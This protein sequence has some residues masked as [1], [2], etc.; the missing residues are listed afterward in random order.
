MVIAYLTRSPWSWTYSPWPFRWAQSSSTVVLVEQSTSWRSVWGAEEACG[1]GAGSWGSTAP[2]YRHTQPRWVSPLSQSRSRDPNLVFL[3]TQLR[4]P[5]RLML[6]CWH[7]KFHFNVQPKNRYIKIDVTATVSLRSFPTH[8]EQ[9]M[10]AVADD[11][12]QVWIR[13]VN[14]CNRS[15]APVCLPVM[16]RSCVIFLRLIQF[17]LNDTK[18]GWFRGQI[19]DCQSRAQPAKVFEQFA[20][21]CDISDRVLKNNTEGLAGK[22]QKRIRAVTHEL[23]LDRQLQCVQHWELRNEQE[24]EPRVSTQ[25]S[26]PMCKCIKI[27]NTMQRAEALSPQLRHGLLIIMV[28]LLTLELHGA[29]LGPKVLPFKCMKFFQAKSKFWFTL[30]TLLKKLFFIFHFLLSSGFNNQ[31]AYFYPNPVH[32][33]EDERI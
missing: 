28:L 22:C 1:P 33:S 6:R 7:T 24:K 12:L 10:R 14:L 9:H 32:N 13:I 27:I 29:I 30:L 26:I 3:V 16:P 23:S 8:E 17:N 11:G 5:F 20:A 15:K 18:N 4:L 2:P 31:Y 25:F 19:I 21:Q